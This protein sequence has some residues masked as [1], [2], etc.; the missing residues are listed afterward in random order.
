MIKGERPAL[1]ADAKGSGSQKENKNEQQD[2]FL[3]RERWSGSF[4]RAFSVPSDADLDNISA[5]LHDGVLQIK[6]PRL[7]P[8]T[9][10]DTK[11]TIPIKYKS[12]L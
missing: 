2:R 6:I 5:D 12:R 10:A 1:A 7:A 9:P 8:S 11:S 3:W 4:S